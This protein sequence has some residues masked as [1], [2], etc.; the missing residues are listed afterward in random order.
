MARII[1]QI[2]AKLARRAIRARELIAD[3]IQR[4][5]PKGR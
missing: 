1:R 4:A 2:K 5:A 3:A